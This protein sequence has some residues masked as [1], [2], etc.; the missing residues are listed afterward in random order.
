VRLLVENGAEVDPDTCRPLFAAISRRNYGVIKYMRGK[1]V[2]VNG[3]ESVPS[4]LQVAISI[5]EAGLCRILL[6]W[7]DLRIDW[8]FSQNGKN[9]FHRIAQNKGTEILDLLTAHRSEEELEQI[10]EALN[11]SLDDVG[12]TPLYYALPDIVLATKMVELGALLENIDTATLA[13]NFEGS[14]SVL[15]FIKM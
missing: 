14:L 1:G 10:N 13:R 8:Q 6:G 4:A 3:S 2:N 9:L 5:N 12:T 7:S 15:S 11:Q